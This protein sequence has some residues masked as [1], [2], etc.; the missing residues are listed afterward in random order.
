MSGDRPG[1][2]GLWGTDDERGALNLV[3]P[4]RV[5]AAL[6]LPT[7]GRIVSLAQPVGP[8]QPTAPHRPRGSRFMMRDA[9]DY[10][11]GARSPGGFRFAEDI[12]QFSTHNGTHADALSHAWC[13]DEM[14]NG[15]PAASVRSTRGAQRLG[16][17]NLAPVLTRG[18][19]LD[20]VELYGRPLPARTS[21][22][23]ADI[24]RAYERAGVEPAAGDAVLIRTGW[25]ESASPDDYFDNEPGI[26]GDA[27]DWLARQDV[28]LVGADNYAVEV[29]PSPEGQTFPGHLA[30]IH[31]AGVPLL[32][33]LA[34]DELA[35]SDRTEFLFVFAP[36][37]L[38]GSTASPIRPLAVL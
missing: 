28:S 12:V 7:E 15:H 33:N 30:L 36:I 16:A 29:Q 13:G 26:S 24:R 4:E 25:W 6:A 21:V 32:E 2:W 9:G 23:A 8:E 17:E 34:L 10:A 35:A 31:A 5:L 20:L 11:L 19:L 1:R 38:Q 22:E 37:G 3:T 18:V 27:A 14:Y